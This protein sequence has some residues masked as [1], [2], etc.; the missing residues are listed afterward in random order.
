MSDREIREDG[1]IRSKFHS[2]K[3][4]KAYL[5]KVKEV[6][7]HGTGGGNTLEYVR[8]GGRADLYYDAIALFHYLIESDGT[9]WEIINPDRWVYHST[10]GS[11]DKNSIGIE[12][13]NLSRDNSAD[14]SQEQ[15]MALHWLI[16]EYLMDRYPK[17][18]VI[19]SHKR[20]IEKR[21][22]GTRTKQCPGT[23]FN[24]NK[25]AS[26][27]QDRDISYEHL[28]GYESYWRIRKEIT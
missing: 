20:A 21:Y 4:R 14:Y 5:G 1:V 28:P 27:M 6:V 24:W 26:Y 25:L 3:S 22:N 8:N 15:Y 11:K 13:E 18:D 2:G 16:F 12:M 19:M 10:R 17:L 9:I 23:G 7:V